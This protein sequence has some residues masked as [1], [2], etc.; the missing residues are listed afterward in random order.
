MTCSL[1]GK[2]PMSRGG[3]KRK[4]RELSPNDPDASRLNVYRCEHCNRHHIGHRRAPG[5]ITT[6]GRR[7]NQ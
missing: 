3:A 6:P 2:Q 5:D 1:T 4:I 7:L